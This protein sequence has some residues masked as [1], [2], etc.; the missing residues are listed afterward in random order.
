VYAAA[1]LR[2]KFQPCHWPLLALLSQIRTC[3]ISR[4]RFVLDLALLAL[5]ALRK[6]DITKAI[7]LALRA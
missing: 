1:T 4:A 7:F 3:F 6:K 5:H 2:D